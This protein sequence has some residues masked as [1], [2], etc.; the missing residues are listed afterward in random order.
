MTGYAKMC[1]GL[2]T[3]KSVLIPYFAAVKPIRLLI[4]VRSVIRFEL[5]KISENL[6]SKTKIIEWHSVVRCIL[7]IIPTIV[8][9]KAAWKPNLL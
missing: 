3:V 9:I 1:P 5:S 7:N 8:L 4:T 6:H 2:L